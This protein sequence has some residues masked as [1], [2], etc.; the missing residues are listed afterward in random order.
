MRWRAVV[1][2]VIALGLFP[3]C[4]RSAPADAPK[5]K[6]VK[7]HEPAA[8]V[9]AVALTPA[10]S[11]ADDLGG[12]LAVAPD[13]KR[14]ALANA[15]G[16]AV[17]RRRQG[18]AHRPGPNGATAIRFSADGKTLHLGSHDVDAA[19][20]A[21]TTA[22]AP[23]DLAP[24]A[25]QAGLPAPAS[26]GLGATVASDPLSPHRVAAAHTARQRPGP[27]ALCEQACNVRGPGDLYRV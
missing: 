1:A 24:W 22:N 17:L 11:V 25:K 4:S 16:R 13:G 23:A 3:G 27:F 18:D 19:T 9:T 14:W 20:G 15:G 7:S 2:G 26:L 8:A 10:G 12:L 6:T 5:G 21:A